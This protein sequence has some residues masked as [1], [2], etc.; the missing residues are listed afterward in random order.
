M[1][2]LVRKGKTY[3]SNMVLYDEQWR[4]AVYDKATEMIRANFADVKEM[5][6][7][8]VGYLADT[9][10]CYEAADI[11]TRRWFVLMLIIW[12]ASE[13]SDQ[14]MNTKVTFPLLQNGSTSILQGKTK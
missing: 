12:E 5:V 13:M 10:Y 2:L 14:W 8:G 1:D 3:Q 11:N 9:D 6:D 4:K 7:A